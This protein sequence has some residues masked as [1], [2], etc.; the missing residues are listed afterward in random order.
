VGL[1]L[2]GL[3]RRNA[4]RRFVYFELV[5]DVPNAPHGSN[6]AAQPLDLVPEDGPT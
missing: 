6:I 5:F 3:Q 1:I 2:A 4:S